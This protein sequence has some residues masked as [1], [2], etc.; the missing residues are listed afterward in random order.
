MTA[1]QMDGLQRALLKYD[2]VG[3]NSGV[4]LV[5][6]EALRALIRAYQ[7]APAPPPEETAAEEEERGA[8]WW[9]DH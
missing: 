6:A 3:T 1:D 8:P 2:T 7:G 4:L 5:S 9:L